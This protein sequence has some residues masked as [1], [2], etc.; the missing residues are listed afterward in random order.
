MTNQLT[1][2]LRE[3]GDSPV[4]RLGPCF[5]LSLETGSCVQRGHQLLIPTPVVPTRVLQVAAVARLGSGRLAAFLACRAFRL[6]RPYL[7]GLLNVAAKVRAVRHQRLQLRL[8]PCVGIL[9][10]AFVAAKHAKSTPSTI[11]PSITRD[12]NSSFPPSFLPLSPFPGIPG[13]QKEA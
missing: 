4:V 12:F 13:L 5:H 3:Q 8:R 6:P 9:V 7:Q 2:D 11:H 1:N 10:R